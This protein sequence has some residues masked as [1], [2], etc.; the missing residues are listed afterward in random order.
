MNTKC[1][2][3]ITSSILSLFYVLRSFWRCPSVHSVT[4]TVKV[5]ALSAAANLN[6]ESCSCEP[7]ESF[8]PKNP[9]SVLKTIR[10]DEE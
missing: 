8:E 9:F 5:F 4:M 1:F 2:L 10:F 3:R 7:E 6:K